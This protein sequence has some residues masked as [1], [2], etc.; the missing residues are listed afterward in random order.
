LRFRLS[1]GCRQIARTMIAPAT[2]PIIP[3]PSLSN[4]SRMRSTFAA[5]EGSVILE[6]SELSC[7]GNRSGCGLL[8][9]GIRGAAHE[10]PDL[11][12]RVDC[13]HPRHSFVLRPA[14]TARGWCHDIHLSGLAGPTA[15]TRRRANPLTHGA[16]GS[17][18]TELGEA[19]V[20]SARLHRLPFAFSAK[21]SLNRSGATPPP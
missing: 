21:K 6:H 16:K 2:A 14:L 18:R 13:G 15:R 9:E 17:C 1:G 12:H 10:R 4:R 19:S 11:S 3:R 7:S 20:S 5:S 8:R